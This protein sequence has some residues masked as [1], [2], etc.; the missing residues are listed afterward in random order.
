[1]STRSAPEIAPE[2]VAATFAR[3]SVTRLRTMIAIERTTAMSP[4]MPAHTFSG[5]RSTIERPSENR[6]PALGARVPR[7]QRIQLPGSRQQDIAVTEI[8]CS[9]E[10]VMSKM[11]RHRTDATGRDFDLVNVAEGFREKENSRSIERPVG[12]LTEP[13]EPAN[14]RRQF[15][16]RVAVGGGG[17]R[18]RG[19]SQKGN[20]NQACRAPGGKPG[21]PL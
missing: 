14:V 10:A 2:V 1:M 13:S 17:P 16:G 21:G 12:P 19:R 7:F 6:Q 5:N 15:V 18:E 3:G 20:H 4:A 9:R 11:V 8:E